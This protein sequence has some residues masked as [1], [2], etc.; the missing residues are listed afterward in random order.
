VAKK[1][2]TP[3]LKISKTDK[4]H[5]KFEKRFL[6][7]GY[8]FIGGIDEAGRGAWAGPLFAAAVI[9][10]KPIK[11]VKD[12]K[13]LTPKQR[14]ELDIIIRKKAIDFGIGF[15]TVEEIDNL[16]LQKANYLAYSRAIEQL[17]SLDFLLIDAYNWKDCPVPYFPIIDGDFQCCSI[18]AASILA[19][20]ARDNLMQDLHKDFGNYGFGTNKGYG[21]KYHQEKLKIYGATIHHRKSF[22]PIFNLK[23]EQQ[24]LKI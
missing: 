6:L 1:S 7:E 13:L 5:F 20:V 23:F 15:S 3:K 2:E 12:S 19:K 11:N 14:E 9:L 22:A 21:T 8:K 16:G 24:N 4:P 17:K 10:E 18:A